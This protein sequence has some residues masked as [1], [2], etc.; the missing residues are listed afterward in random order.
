M[1]EVLA[2]C[3]VGRINQSGRAA[4]RIEKQLRDINWGWGVVLGRDGRG[5]TCRF[6]LILLDEMQIRVASRMKVWMR[7]RNVL[8]RRRGGEK[9]REKRIGREEK[10]R[11]EE[12]EK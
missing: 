5:C 11:G 6:G 1:G 2:T 7:C 8:R 9:K 3:W 4:V 12:G 10:E